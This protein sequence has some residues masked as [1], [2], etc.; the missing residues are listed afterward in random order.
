[1]SYH[2]GYIERRIAIERENTALPEDGMTLNMAVG[3]NCPTRCEGCYH[4]FGNTALHGGLVTADEVIDFVEETRAE[5]IEQ[6]TLYGGDPLSHPQIVDIV[7]GIHERGFRVKLDTVG[8]A[9][10]GPAQI[11]YKGRGTMDQVDAREL[12]PYVDHVSIPLDVWASQDDQ[13]DPAPALFRRGRPNLFEETKRIANLLHDAGISFGINTVANASNVHK[14]QKIVN[15][16]EDIGAAEIQIFEF[17]PEGPNPTS[18]R[19]DLILGEGVFKQAVQDLRPNSSGMKIITKAFAG[20]PG[21]YFMVEESGLAFKRQQGGGRTILGHITRDR[22]AVRKALHDHNRSKAWAAGQVPT[23]GASLFIMREEG[24][25]LGNK[26][27]DEEE[28]EYG[29]LGGAFERMISLGE[30]AMRDLVAREVGTDLRIKEPKF[31]ALSNVLRFLPKHLVT[32]N[33]IAEW[34]EGEPIPVPTSSCKVWEWHPLAALPEQLGVEARQVVESMRTGRMLFDDG[35][36][37]A[38]GNYL[39]PVKPIIYLPHNSN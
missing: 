9:F 26:R 22:S 15:I 37:D 10:L 8:T 21:S 28:F 11:L 23:V 14:L 29:G 20:R 24:I 13:S 39:D 6:V 36:R 17:D 25:L 33:F 2:D 35:N 4:F 38:V 1:M 12:A 32:M 31:V 27:I 3:P 5:G 30:A 16:A 18:K 19:D 7:R 34:A